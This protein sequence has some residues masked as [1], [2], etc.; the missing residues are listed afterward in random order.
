MVRLYK[1]QFGRG[2]TKA[3]TELAGYDTVISTLEGSL[4]PAERRLW[5]WARISACATLGSSSSTPPRL[6]SAT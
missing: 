1:E 6:S 3:R 4:T 2:P 5:S